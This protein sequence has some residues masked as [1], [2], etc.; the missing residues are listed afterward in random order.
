METW[1]EGKLKILLCF[2]QKVRSGSVSK[3]SSLNCE[4]PRPAACDRYRISW[5]CLRADFS[6]LIQRK[7]GFVGIKEG[8][9]KTGGIK[10]RISMSKI[11]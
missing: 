10:K 7:K 2:K 3:K 4:R 8:K 1:T 9:V 11:D 6:G 5:N